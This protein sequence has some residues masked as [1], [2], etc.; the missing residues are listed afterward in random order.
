[1][2]WRICEPCHSQN[3]FIC[4]NKHWLIC[5]CNSP[6]R[7]ERAYREGQKEYNGLSYSKKFHID[8]EI[9]VLIQ[10][11]RRTNYINKNTNEQYVPPA[12]W[13]T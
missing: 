11:I 2:F 6:G 4:D 12:C 13:M 3:L 8:T 5:E 10:S 7:A 9:D 1:M